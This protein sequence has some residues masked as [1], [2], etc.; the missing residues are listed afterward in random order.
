MIYFYNLRYVYSQYLF[1]KSNYKFKISQKKRD[2]LFIF[3]YSWRC[4]CIDAMSVK[5]TWWISICTNEFEKNLSILRVGKNTEFQEIINRYLNSK[6][7][8]PIICNTN[9]SKQRLRSIIKRIQISLGISNLILMEQNIFNLFKIP[10][11]SDI[12]YGG[13]SLLC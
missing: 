8:V 6:H 2:I 13:L 9:I 5:R 10:L 11:S 1:R 4:A 7:R 12:K 3:N